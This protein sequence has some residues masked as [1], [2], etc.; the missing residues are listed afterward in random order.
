V[1]VCVEVATGQ[2]RGQCG[3][4]HGAVVSSGALVLAI[5]STCIVAVVKLCQTRS[6][7]VGRS[8]TDM[9]QDDE[10]SWPGYGAGA[11]SIP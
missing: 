7:K 5:A 3:G 10:W 8:A 9:E 4:H 1:C 11:V 6:V 2:C